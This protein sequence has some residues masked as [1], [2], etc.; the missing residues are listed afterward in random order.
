MDSDADATESKSSQSRDAI[1]S[2][3]DGRATQSTD[4]PKLKCPMEY[5][6]A[7]YF[8]DVLLTRSLPL[9]RPL[10]ARA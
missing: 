10:P 7:F 3:R 6:R 9:T 1:P 4:A 5:H 8:G 2:T